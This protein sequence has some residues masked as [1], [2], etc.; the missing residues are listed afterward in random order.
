MCERSKAV[1]AEGMRGEESFATDDGDDDEAATDDE[2]KGGGGDAQ[3]RLLPFFRRWCYRLACTHGHPT[4]GVEHRMEMHDAYD[5][6]IDPG[7]LK[8]FPP[9]STVLIYALRW[10]S[11]CP[12]SFQPSSSF[13][14][15]LSS[16]E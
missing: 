5:E 11:P 1:S 3:Y 7:R 8:R 4:T 9:S 6:L 15:S 10:G 12:P 14:S 13:H 2:G 16:S